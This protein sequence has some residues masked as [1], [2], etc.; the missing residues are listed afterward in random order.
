MQFGESWSK[1]G[2]NPTLERLAIK[3]AIRE[4]KVGSN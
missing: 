1:A 4:N 3:D 2:E